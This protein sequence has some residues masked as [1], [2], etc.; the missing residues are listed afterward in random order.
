MIGKVRFFDKTAGRDI[1][2]VLTD[3]IR[4]V[5]PDHPTVAEVLNDVLEGELQTKGPADG[6]FIGQAVI[7]AARGLQGH[8]ELEPKESPPDDVVY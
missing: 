2:A 3:E 5:C 6:D 8:Y 4:W 7:N 1:E